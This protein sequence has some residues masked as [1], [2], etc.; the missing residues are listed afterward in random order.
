MGEKDAVSSITRA[1]CSNLYSYSPLD[2]K[3]LEETIQGGALC[4][5]QNLV[6]LQITLQ[7]HS[8][9][10]PGTK[11]LTGREEQRT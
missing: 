6:A 10:K 8:R 7:N 9:K 1:D 11:L 5:S 4:L 2:V 3:A